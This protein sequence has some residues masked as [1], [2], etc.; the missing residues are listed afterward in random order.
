M[1]PQLHHGPPLGELVWSCVE[2]G[3]YVA[4]CDNRFLGFV[5]RIEFEIFQ[6]CDAHSQQIGLFT[7]LEA[8]QS[9]LTASIQHADSSA[10]GV[11]EL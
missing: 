2:D 5:D 10:L 8:A 4:S 6:V 7:T 9:C 11:T 1:N 3:F